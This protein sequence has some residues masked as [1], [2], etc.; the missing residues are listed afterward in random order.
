LRLFITTVIIV[1][2]TL[3]SLFSENNSINFENFFTVNRV[4]TPVVSPDGQNI[5]FTVKKANI[6]EN[7]YTTQIWLMDKNGKNL[8][9][10]TSDSSA[11]LH[12]I[13]SSNGEILYFL[14]S[15]SGSNQI[16]K[17]SLS[18][19]NAQQ[20]SD[21]Y[22]DIEGF[23]LSPNDSH[24]IFI[25][26][27]LPGCDT[28]DCIKKHGEMQKNNPVK[29]RV[30]DNLMYRH[31]NIWLEGQYSH[32]FLL[33]IDGKSIKDLTP[34]TYH[35]PPISLGSNH[36]YSFS[37]D[38]K[39]ISYVT[40]LDKNIAISTNNDLFAISSAGSV[41][42]K[43]SLGDGNDN[44]P[45]YSPDGKY[46][47][48]ASMGQPGFEADR[49]R[50]ILY[51]RETKKSKELTSGFDLSVGEILWTAD[52]KA[53]YFTAE[54][55]GNNSIY[56]VAI[57]DPV[58]ETVLKGHNVSGVQFLNQNALVFAKQ[59]NKMPFEI[60][61]YDFKNKKLTPLTH[62]NDNILKNFDLPDYEEFWFS[63]AQG[64]SIQGF[65]M[66][67]PQYE[68]GKKYP[69]V[70]LIH[71]GPQG[72]WSNEWH[73]RWNYQMFA[74]PGYVVYYINFHGS[75][76]YGQ[77]FTNSISQHWGDLP[78]EDLIKGTEYIIKHYD[79]VDPDRLGAAGASYGGFMINWIAGHDNSYKCL[80][81]HDGVYD[82]VSMW[83]STEELWFPE[84]EMGG[85]PWQA[86]S[87]YGKWSPSRLAANF[88]TPTLVIHGEHDYRV[89][90]T[91][92]LQFFTALQ[93]QSVPS[94]LLFFPDEDHFVRKPKNAQLWWKIIHEWFA[95]YLK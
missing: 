57:A 46:I 77:E 8:N 58:I 48:Y 64:D 54:E 6:A 88:K 44:N 21:V 40:N 52:S 69:A 65:I 45:Q 31:W 75:R 91:Q 53:V 76:G 94:R 22:G 33:S 73:F 36:D 3:S 89:P 13:F 41:P 24:F 59:T 68:E 62:F 34:G 32:L 86:G 38:G 67:P 87:V 25:R 63:G 56:R 78:Y 20:V 72:M 79:F 23:A 5:A 27:V 39:E 83:G 30:I 9:Q 12:P 15:R 42:A 90:Y 55:A 28:E 18:G 71:G 10:L 74:S 60:F 85:L 50:I 84:W 43:I 11:S 7:S 1:L 14:N 19:G 82:Q 51:N 66:K 4:G 93:R 16:W 49:V 95:K 17:I 81:S 47:A 70:H 37:P 29:A 2:V 92:G 35:T 61:T 26:K 80:V